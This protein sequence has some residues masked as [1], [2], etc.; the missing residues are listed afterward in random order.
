MKDVFFI[1]FYELSTL[2]FTWIYTSAK[3]LNLSSEDSLKRL[4]VLDEPFL[5]MRGLYKW[6]PFKEKKTFNKNP[7]E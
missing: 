4:Q 2:T 3:N 5:N 1:F 7:I 6:F